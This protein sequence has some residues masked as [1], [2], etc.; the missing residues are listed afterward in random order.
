MS[1]PM[2][3]LVTQKDDRMP[4]NQLKTL[5]RLFALNTG[6]KAMQMLGVFC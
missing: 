4:M 6:E 3:V 1:H 2:K 5:V